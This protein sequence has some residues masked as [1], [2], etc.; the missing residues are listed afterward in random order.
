MPTDADL[1]TLKR[2]RAWWIAAARRADPRR[3]VLSTV[4]LAVGL[5]ENSASTVSDWEN[6]LGGGP[7]IEQLHLLAA[8]YNLPVKVFT[9]PEATDQEFLDGFRALADAAIEL[10]HEDLARAAE[11]AGP[12]DSPPGPSPRRR[13]A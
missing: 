4:A 9:E 3:P 1:A 7:S 2:R 11:D 12:Y 5:K 10:A 6:N 13:T 8:F